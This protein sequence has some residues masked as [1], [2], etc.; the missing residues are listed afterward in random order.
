MFLVVP[1]ADKTADGFI[2]HRSDGPVTVTLPL[3]N[4]T[5]TTL[6]SV[7]RWLSYPKARATKDTLITWINEHLSTVP[8]ADAVARWPVLETATNPSVLS[9]ADRPADW[10]QPFR[11]LVRQITKETPQFAVHAQATLDVAEAAA[12][13]AG[14]EAERERERLY[15][16]PAW[17]ESATDDAPEGPHIVVTLSDAEQRHDGYCSEVSDGDLEE[18][19]AEERDMYLPLRPHGTCQTDAIDEDGDPWDLTTKTEWREY[20]EDHCCCG[21]SVI[22]RIVSAV[23]VTGQKLISAAGDD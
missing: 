12:R 9:R 2:V 19:E 23:T 17:L 8:M 6:L 21:A 11:A 22:T 16:P 4:N 5:I 10:L 7:A 20:M 3:E 1:E 14:A 18:R 15:T 13:T